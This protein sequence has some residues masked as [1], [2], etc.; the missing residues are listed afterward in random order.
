MASLVRGNT[1]SPI[2]IAANRHHRNGYQISFIPALIRS[3]SLQFCLY[4]QNCCTR[5]STSDYPYWLCEGK[6]DFT[7]ISPTNA[8]RTLISPML[9]CSHVLIKTPP[10]RPILHT[11]QKVILPYVLPPRHSRALCDFLPPLQT[12]DRVLSRPSQVFALFVDGDPL[13]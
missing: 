8:L 7:A 9:G 10:L 5:Y 2:S 3:F 6:R 4:P 13:G 12:D 11:A 1:F